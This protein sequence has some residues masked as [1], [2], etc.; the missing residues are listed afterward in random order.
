MLE[1]C[2]SFVSP[3]PSPCSSSTSSSFSSSSS[4]SSSAGFPSTGPVDRKQPR[5]RSKIAKVLKSERNSSDR[6]W[7]WKLLPFFHYSERVP[8][9]LI[10]N[11]WKRRLGV[12]IHNLVRSRDEGG[13]KG[14]LLTSRF[15]PGWITPT[16]RLEHSSRT[17][18]FC[19]Y[20]QA[21]ADRFLKTRFMYTEKQS[22]DQG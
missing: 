11:W 15:H 17:T 12:R 13:S 19:F 18:L 2:L 20:R 22:Q 7:K 14:T 21:E 3:S 10:W 8:W 9:R 4:A 16:G 1:G 5:L 6:E